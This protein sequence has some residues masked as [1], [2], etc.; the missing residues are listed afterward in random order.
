MNRR[1]SMWWLIY[2][3]I[4]F[5]PVAS[6]VSLRPFDEFPDEPVPEKQI[7]DVLDQ[8]GDGKYLSLDEL[9]SVLRH[10]AHYGN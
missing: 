7:E 3:D 10:L 6:F 1:W 4:C 5:T 9:G 2:F 8:T